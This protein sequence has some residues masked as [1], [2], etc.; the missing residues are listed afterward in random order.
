MVQAKCLNA[1]H[2]ELGGGSGGGGEGGGVYV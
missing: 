2:I 1:C